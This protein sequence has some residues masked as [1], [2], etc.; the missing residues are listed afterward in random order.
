MQPELFDKHGLVTGYARVT[1]PVSSQL[2]VASLGRDTGYRMLVID[3]VHRFT[4]AHSCSVTDDDVVTHLEQ[5][6]RRRHQRNV[7]ARTRGLLEQEGWLERS[8]M[9]RRP[10]G[11]E[12]ISYCL[13]PPA[14]A[15]ITKEK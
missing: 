2:T 15:A 13:T 3:A 4:C 1:D 6:T 8:V 10:D 12:V 11:R 5:H 7:I 14:L 9:V